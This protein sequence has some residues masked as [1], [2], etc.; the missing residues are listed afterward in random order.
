MHAHMEE[1]SPR[2]GAEHL[3][4][5]L[6]THSGIRGTDGRRHGVGERT[7]G[8]TQHPESNLHKHSQARNNDDCD[9]LRK[10]SRDSSGEHEPDHYMWV[11]NIS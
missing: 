6:L 9:K 7:L 8:C 1:G 11:R 5:P 4:L 3:D 2:G 10:M